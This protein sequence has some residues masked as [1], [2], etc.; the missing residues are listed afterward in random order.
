MKW[1]LMSIGAVMVLGC[2]STPPPEP[3]V[4]GPYPAQWVTDILGQTANVDACLSQFTEPSAVFHARQLEDGVLGL[5][6][7]DG[8]G[9]T[10]GCTVQ[11]SRVVETAEMDITVTDLRGSPRYVTGTEPPMHESRR[12]FEGADG[13]VIGWVFWP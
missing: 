1:M 13:T 2:A 4:A 8:G 7:I 11:M 10:H 6:V 9:E 12:S 3:E 5:A